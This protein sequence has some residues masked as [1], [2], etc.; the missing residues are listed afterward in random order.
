MLL[1]KLA[2]FT[3]LFSDFPDNTDYKLLGIKKPLQS[4]FMDGVQLPQ[5]QSHFKEAVYFLPLSSQKF[6]VTHYRTFIFSGEMLYFCLLQIQQQTQYQFDLQAVVNLFHLQ[7]STDKA[8]SLTFP[9]PLCLE[10]NEI[11]KLLISSNKKGII[12]ADV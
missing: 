8:F 2:F 5:G 6:L 7:N 1:Y 11:N 12:G 4:L 3:G 10:H 9:S